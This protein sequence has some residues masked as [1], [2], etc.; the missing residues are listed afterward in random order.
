MPHL[1]KLRNIQIERSLGVAASGYLSVGMKEFHKVRG[2][3]NMPFQ[4]GLG[5]IAIAIELMLKA[6]IAKRAFIFLY[7][8]LPKDLQIKILYSKDNEIALNRI[9]EMG[10]TNFT[11]KS[12]ELNHCISVF[13]SLLPDKK[14]TFKT[15]FDVLSINRNTAVHAVI[16]DFQRYDLERVAYTALQLVNILHEQKV[17]GFSRASLTHDDSMFVA[18]YDHE[19][20]ERVRK[21]ISAAREKSKSLNAPSFLLHPHEWESFVVT[22]PIC[23]GEGIM[24]GY[25]EMTWD[26]VDG[27][28]MVHFYGDEYS[29][30]SCQLK[31][32]DSAE[33]SL[34]G[35]Q[36]VFE[37]EGDADKWIA[38]FG[39]L[40]PPS[41][42][43]NG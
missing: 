27:E 19:R 35:M 12:A 16:Q 32:N 42:H 37:R 29:C 33:I 9:E 40:A 5:I 2:N 20:I 8:S 21:S 38:E 4:V 10:L 28:D 7:E 17:A 6:L 34:A 41:H 14:Q 25:S 3:V 24:N 31:L 18:Q 23:D 13:Y 43:E 26:Q 30:P 36:N 39:D 11:Y 22:C 15:S 1:P